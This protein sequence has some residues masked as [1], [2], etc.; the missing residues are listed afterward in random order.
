VDEG[1]ERALR[2]DG[3]GYY[4]RNYT[5]IGTIA[6]PIFDQMQILNQVR[7]I[8]SVFEIGCTTGFRLEKA[9]AAFGARC[10]GLE[11]SPTAVA[12]AHERYPA[13]DVREGTAPRD[14]RHWESSSFDVVVVGHVLYLLPRSD[15]FALAAAVDRLLVDGGHII[16]MDFLSPDAHH[17]RYSHH[18]ELSVF[19]HDP[20]GPWVWSPT[21]E[22]VSRQV[23]PLADVVSSVVNPRS[24]QTVDVVRKL[25]MVDGYPERPAHPS[26][27]DDPGAA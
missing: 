23:Y 21:F 25:N 24:W 9:R 19:K 12:E 4:A 8:Q 16:V 14:M 15:L 7:P 1:Q 17:S 6:D 3:D 27:H 2:T 22:L 18:P 13:V 20:S 26:V 5:G 10:A 11:I